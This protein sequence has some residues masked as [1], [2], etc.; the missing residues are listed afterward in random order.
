MHS[1]IS[2]ELVRNEKA[3]GKVPGDNEELQNPGM[4]NHR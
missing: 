1:S 4:T 2:K 3:E